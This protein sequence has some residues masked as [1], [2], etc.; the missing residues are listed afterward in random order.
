MHGRDSDRVRVL[1]RGRVF[2]K[3][4]PAGRS[5][6]TWYSDDSELPHS[7]SV[8]DLYAGKG[9]NYA[10]YSGTPVIPFGF[11]MSYTTFRYVMACWQCKHVP[12][13]DN[14]RSDLK[15]VMMCHAQ[16]LKSGAQY[17]RHRPV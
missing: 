16:L 5:P 7:I 1:L 13:N 10:Y 11:G 15:R 8:M 3:V 4:S 14:V 2:G 17:E 6:V 12:V 9:L